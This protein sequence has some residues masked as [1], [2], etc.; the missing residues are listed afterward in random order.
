MQC[1][2]SSG[3]VPEFVRTQGSRGEVVADW[4][5]LDAAVDVGASECEMAVLAIEVESE[6]ERAYIL[7]TVRDE[8]AWLMA[9]RIGAADEAVDVQLTARVGHFGDGRQEDR[10]ISRVRGRLKQLRGVATHPLD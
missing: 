7:R 1:C 6:A 2:S 4:N 3:S 9:R 5:D 10:L 8:P